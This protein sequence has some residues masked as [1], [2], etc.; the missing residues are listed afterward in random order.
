MRI[1]WNGHACFFLAGEEGRVLTDP[2]VEAVPYELLTTEADVI[3]VSHDHDDHNATH[4]VNGAPSIIDGVGEFLIDGIPFLGVASFHDAAEG[5]ERGANHIY[6]FTL[7]G[8]RVAHLGDLG[9][10]LDEAQ[11]EALA[12]V[13]V[14]LIPVGGCFTI[15]AAQAAEVIRSLPNLR[16]AIPMHYKTDRLP[17]WPVE[18]VEPFLDMMDNPRHI[19]SPQVELSKNDLPDALEVWILDYA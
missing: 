4:R 7:D 11:L 5:A 13:E 8:I 1:Q 19:G 16:I 18:T 12:D 14:L 3:T 17:N 9:A 10:S 2:Y 6:A 15:D